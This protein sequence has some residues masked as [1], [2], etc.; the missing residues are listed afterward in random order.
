[1]ISSLIHKV[2]C[3]LHS[4]SSL[5]F[6]AF[7]ELQTEVSDVTSDLGMTGIPIWDYKQY[8]FKVLFP[9]HHDHP[10]L[11]MTMDVS[12]YLHLQLLPAI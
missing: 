12:R 9:S 2:A 7:A 11:H 8:T 4:V 6:V 5:F 3:L 1:M 10:V